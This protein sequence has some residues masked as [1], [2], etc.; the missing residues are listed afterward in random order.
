M[1]TPWRLVS[2][3]ADCHDGTP[4]EQDDPE[5]FGEFCSICGLT[6]GDECLCPRPTQDEFEYEVF[7]D[8]LYAQ[9]IQ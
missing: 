4:G 1:N 2:F 6:Y 7:D 8:K 5:E 9:E 3:A